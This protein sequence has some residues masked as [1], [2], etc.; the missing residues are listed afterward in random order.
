M[1][2]IDTTNVFYRNL[3][4]HILSLNEIENYIFNLI[5]K[6]NIEDYVVGVDFINKDDLL[7]SYSFEDEI[8]KINVPKI[9]S[10]ATKLYDEYSIKGNKILFINLNIIEAILHEVVHGIQ[11]CNLMEQDYAYNMLYAKELEYKDIISDE[12][13][14]KYYYLFSYERDAMITSMENILHIIKTNYKNEEKIF[15]YFLYNIY[16]YL[17]LGYTIKNF[18]IKSPAEKICEELYH[19]NTPILSNIDTYD[20][21]KLGYQMNFKNYNSFKRNKV[22]KILVKNDLI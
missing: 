2:F 3:D 6:I 10:E 17:V 5:I 18:N 8:I 19:E 20:R 15:N 13:Y 22:K 21:M 12:L 7:G 11:N 14:N 1:I 4:T 16:N 9:I